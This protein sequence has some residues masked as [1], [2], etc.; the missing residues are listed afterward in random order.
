MG[1]SVIWQS[2]YVCKSYINNVKLI[3]WF[4]FQ[5]MFYNKTFYLRKIHFELAS[6]ASYE[7]FINKFL[8]NP[9]QLEWLEEVYIDGKKPTNFLW[10][11]FD[12]FSKQY[13]IKVNKSYITHYQVMLCWHR[14]IPWK[15]FVYQIIN[16][17]DI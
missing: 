15:R 14:S 8:S 11:P 17:S 13:V 2:L 5:S 16:V 10:S 12:R 9:S 1:Q 4:N 3:Y 6:S 7:N